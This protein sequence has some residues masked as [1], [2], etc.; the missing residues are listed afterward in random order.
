[1]FEQLIIDVG[2]NADAARLGKGLGILVRHER[3]PDFQRAAAAERSVAIDAG[4]HLLKH[5]VE[6][7]VLE[8]LCTRL[9]LGFDLKR[10]LR[11]RALCVAD[12]GERCGKIYR[13]R[14]HITS[15]SAWMAPAAFIACKITIRSRGPMPSALSPSTICWS[16]TPACTT[17][18]PLPSSCTP[19]EERGTTT[20]RPRDKGPG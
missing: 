4:E 2:G 20:V 3:A 5:R 1:M 17:A 12:R 7:R 10:G 19:T 8:L 15:I 13:A 11:L 6:E 9:G 14:H 18:S 16:E